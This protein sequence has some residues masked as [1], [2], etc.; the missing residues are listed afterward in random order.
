MYESLCLARERLLGL[1]EARHFVIV[2][3]AVHVLLRLTPIVFL[4]VSMTADAAW[5]VNRAASIASGKGYAEEGLL[6]AYWPVGYPGFLGTTFWL[7][8][9]SVLVAQLANVC[10]SALS[11]LLCLTVARMILRDEM[12]ARLALLLFTMYPN[13]VLYAS[14]SMSE[15]FFTTVFLF[16]IFLF[17]RF[18]TPYG[19]VSCGLVFGLGTLTKPQVMFFP[20]LLLGR[21]F[22]LDASWARLRNTT[23]FIYAAVLL[24]LG[25][26]A[27]RN[28]VVFEEFVL[29][30]TNGGTNLL[31]GNNPHA[32]GTYRSNDALFTRIGFS[33]ADQVAADRRARQLAVDWIREQPGRFLAL[34]PRKLWHTWAIDG[35]AE[36]FY[37][38]GHAAYERRAVWFRLVRVFNQAFYLTL[39]VMAGV[40]I[41]AMIRGRIPPPSPWTCLIYWIVLYFTTISVVFIGGPRFHFPVMPWTIMG[42]AWGIIFLSRAARFNSPPGEPREGPARRTEVSNVRPRICPPGHVVRITAARDGSVQMHLSRI[43]P[44][45]AILRIE[46]TIGTVLR[47]LLTRGSMAMMFCPLQSLSEPR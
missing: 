40:M 12:V 47:K 35:E 37:Q 27:I 41:W 42:A 11:A 4:S 1:L 25:P 38:A 28:F 18:P 23:V 13:N 10:L 31:I 33:V 15:I 26:W 22:L 5:Y 39:L 30:S 3:L 34:I 24:V 7:F 36:W 20:L 17:L 9:S 32:T 45:H 43:R 16:G 2:C 19:A 6:T 29:V 46:L 21:Q 14:I 44:E 8:G